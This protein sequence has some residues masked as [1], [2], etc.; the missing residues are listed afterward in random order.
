MRPIGRYYPWC[1]ILSHSMKLTTTQ[2]SDFQQSLV[3]DLES[4]VWD[5]VKTYTAELCNQDAL[6]DEYK[7][8]REQLLTAQEGL[9]I[10]FN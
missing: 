9:T 5:F 4:Q 6:V 10:S 1:S 3:D 7:T 2:I 8:V